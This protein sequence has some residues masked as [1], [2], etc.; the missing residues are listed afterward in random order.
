MSEYYGENP[1]DCTSAGF[2]LTFGSTFIRRKVLPK[3]QARRFWDGRLI[4]SY[5]LNFANNE[6]QIYEFKSCSYSY[7][8]AYGTH[9]LGDTSNSTAFMRG[10]EVSVR[11]SSSS[12]RPSRRSGAKSSSPLLKPFDSEHVTFA[13]FMSESR[14]FF[15]EYNRGWHLGDNVGMMAFDMS[16]P[17]IENWKLK[18][19]NCYC[20]GYG[21]TIGLCVS[22]EYRFAGRWLLAA[23]FGR[24]DS[25]YNGYSDDGRIDIHSSVVPYN[26]NTPI[27]STTP[28]RGIPTR[29]VSQSATSAYDEPSDTGVGRLFA[30]TH[31][32]R[33][34][35]PRLQP[36]H[37]FTAPVSSRIP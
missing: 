16:K 1:A 27:H 23:Y 21:M 32:L 6:K 13:I 17:C 35:S 24:M 9:S 25:R 14:R 2:F 34:L 22:C 31:A 15:E 10:R 36:A 7:S 8:S 4:P 37:R 3:S 26:P 30:G 12:S 19:G 5:R 18:F 28:R 11:P 29:S 33:P 20:K